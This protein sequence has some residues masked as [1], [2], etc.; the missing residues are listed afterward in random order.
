MY[1][2]G[3]EERSPMTIG[4]LLSLTEN[5]DPSASS[6]SHGGQGTLRSYIKSS[7]YV[8]QDLQD[9]QDGSD[10]NPVFSD[11]IRWILKTSY[12]FKSLDCWKS[13]NLWVS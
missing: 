11:R 1:N 6:C 9:P 8:R 7:A 3:H 13:N 12:P 2:C 4:P 10:G 5:A